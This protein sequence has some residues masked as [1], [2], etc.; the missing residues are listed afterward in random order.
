MHSSEV[1]D[2]VYLKKRLIAAGNMAYFLG[3]VYYSALLE[4]LKGFDMYKLKQSCKD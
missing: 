4:T 1:D 3:T 2:S